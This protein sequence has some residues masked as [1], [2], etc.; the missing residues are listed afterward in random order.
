MRRGRYSMAEEAV[1]KDTTKYDVKLKL[2]Y[3][4]VKEDG[5]KFA[6][7]SCNLNYYG[8]N[9]M[10]VTVTEGLC[11]GFS[12]SLVDMGFAGAAMKGYAADLEKLKAMKAEK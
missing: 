4:I 10:Q 1:T 6:D 5:T 9:I 2:S 8:M 11:V 7:V 3:D 12:Q